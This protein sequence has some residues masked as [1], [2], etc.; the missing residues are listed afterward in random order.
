MALMLQ[1]CKK[2]DCWVF[3]TLGWR[4]TSSSVVLL[5]LSTWPPWVF[6]VLAECG[7][8]SVIR[9]TKC[10]QSLPQHQGWVL[11]RWNLNLVWTGAGGGSEHVT[12]VVASAQDKH[13]CY[14]Y[15]LLLFILLIELKDWRMKDYF[16][17]FVKWILKCPPLWCYRISGR[18]NQAATREV[19]EK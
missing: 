15:L 4:H 12:Q 1:I 11:N 3:R 19:S 8:I 6:T 2:V 5:H 14:Y 16:P 10:H 17:P 7:I 9:K 13:H 18:S